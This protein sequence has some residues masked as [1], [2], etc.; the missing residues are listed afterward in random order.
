MLVIVLLWCI[1]LSHALAHGAVS[2]ADMLKLSLL[3]STIY[4]SLQL[5][6]PNECYDSMMSYC[7]HHWELRSFKMLAR[8]CVSL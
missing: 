6:I 8:D 4:A 5:T 2:V 7:S 3:P 1:H